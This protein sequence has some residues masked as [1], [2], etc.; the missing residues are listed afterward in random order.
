MLR[1][2]LRGI[3]ARRMRT[4]NTALAI[5]LG[6]MLI[7]GT[8]V[9]TDTIDSSFGKIFEEGA[10]GTDVAVVP[11][12]I[13]E[14]ENG[15]G[16]PPLDAR[17]LEQVRGADGVQKAEAEIF[18]VGSV[19]GKDGERLGV[20]GAP[21][22]VVSADQKPF[23]PFNYVEGRPPASRDEAALDRLTA[24]KEGFRVGDRIRIGGAGGARTYRLVGIAKYGTV[25]SFGGAVI[26]ILT[27]PEAQRALDYGPR[28][29]SVAVQA[30]PGTTRDQLKA[31][32]RLPVPR[33]PQPGAEVP[34]AQHLDQH[35]RVG[36]P[37][38]RAPP[39]QRA[40]R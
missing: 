30:Q 6:V 39:R 21:N 19:F 31:N 20:G 36:H 34:A 22:F 17:I 10:K 40:R 16:P 28:F 37:R 38:H 5:A 7:A 11:K 35:S 13:V 9:L 33:R 14:D 8:Y 29:D 3:A 25:S 23:S 4:F 15:A 18:N 1:V 27:L 12:T 32:R 2:A 26:A 24:D